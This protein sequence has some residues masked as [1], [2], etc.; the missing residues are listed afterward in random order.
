M[1]VF[2][3]ADKVFF[4]AVISLSFLYSC[5]TD[6]TEEKP[7]EYYYFPK[8]NIYY[9]VKEANY[10]YSLDSGRQ[11]QK[12]KNE[13]SN[14]MPIT[15]GGK[16]LISGTGTDIWK[17]NE[18]HRAL[19]G[20]MLYNIITKDTALLLQN[21]GLRPKELKKTVSKPDTPVN[22]KKKKNFFQRIFGKKN[23]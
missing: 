14:E 2:V 8:T 19:Y 3:W 17:D 1:K 16:I 11:W 21:P 22:T 15:L 13:G 20:G 9:D 18:S 10:I 12:M 4:I 7:A 6:V 5:K 23:K